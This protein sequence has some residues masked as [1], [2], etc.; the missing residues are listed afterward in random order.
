M[1]CALENN[2]TDCPCTYESCPRRGKCCECV[3]YH[4]DK[5]QFPGCFFTPEGERTY[6]RS[7]AGLVRD[8]ERRR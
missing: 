6:D 1:E 2:R 7:F 5:G 3:V 4:R 8:R